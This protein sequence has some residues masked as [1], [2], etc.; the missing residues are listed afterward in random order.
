MP[1]LPVGK[2]PAELLEHSVNFRHECVGANPKHGV[3]AHISGSDLV[4]D[5]DGCAP[6]LVDI[7]VVQALRRLVVAARIDEPRGREALDDFQSMPLER[8]AHDRL[9][10]RMW[11][12]R[13]NLTAYDAAYVALA[14]ALDDRTL[15]LGVRV[16]RRGLR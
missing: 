10:D 3:W 5:G 11:E 2:L 14:E 13:G 12:L 8:Y 4:R 9:I 7:E 16:S 6:C 1:F 15:C